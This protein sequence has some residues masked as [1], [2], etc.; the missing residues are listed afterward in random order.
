[1]KAALN[2]RDQSNLTLELPDTSKF[3]P[4]SSN[5]FKVTVEETAAC[6]RYAYGD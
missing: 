1:M 5:N 4:I 6:P 3:T 2:F